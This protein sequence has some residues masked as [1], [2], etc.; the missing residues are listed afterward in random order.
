MVSGAHAPVFN[1]NLQLNI[2][3]SDAPIQLEIGDHTAV[4]N[5]T[6]GACTFDCLSLEPEVPTNMSLCLDQGGEVDLELIW[7][8]LA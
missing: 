2:N 8:P 5:K 6:I 4:S 7:W 1:E 3:R